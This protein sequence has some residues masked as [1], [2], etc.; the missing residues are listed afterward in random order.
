MDEANGSVIGLDQTRWVVQ[1]ASFVEQQGEMGGLDSINA[2]E[3]FGPNTRNP[4]Q[5]E[6]GDIRGMGGRGS[7]KFMP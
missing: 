7:L 1:S 3:F 2:T 5:D 6:S 4:S